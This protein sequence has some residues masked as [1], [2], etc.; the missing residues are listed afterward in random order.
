MAEF[1]AV[2][3]RADDAPYAVIVLSD[4]IRPGFTRAYRWVPNLEEWVADRGLLRDFRS[5]PLDRENAFEA[6]DQATASQLVRRLPPITARWVLDAYRAEDE[7]LTSTQLGL[8][9]VERARPVTNPQMAEA[10][11]TAPPWAWVRV[12]TFSADK[13]LA[14]R[15]WASEVRRG[16]KVRLAPLGRLEARVGRLDDGSGLIVEVRRAPTSSAIVETAERI[17]TAAHAGQLDKAGRP[18]IDHPRRVA[19]RL[20]AAGAPA[21]AVAAGWLHDVVEDTG[22]TAEDL[23]RAGVPEEA[24]AA[25]LAVT[26]RAGES[27]EAYAGR[28]SQTPLAAEVKR[29]DLADNTDPQRLG[30]LDETTR[31]RLTKKY[32]RMV[33]L[34]SESAGI[35]DQAAGV[36]AHAGVRGRV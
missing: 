11:R 17:A 24:V 1:Y 13:A 26:K 20:A 29:A 33:V 23:L 30:L 32:Q 36:R 5:S 19:T 3:E 28:V 18:Y 7:R 35:A 22:T 12:R 10:V 16:K 34:L 21:E 6:I 15:T 8:T 9:P 2:R 31:R 4:Q 14:A 27:A 25:V